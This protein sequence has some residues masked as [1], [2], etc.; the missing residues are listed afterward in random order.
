MASGKRKHAEDDHLSL[1]KNAKK[2]KL[3]KAS[4]GKQKLENTTSD[5]SKTKS[6]NGRITNKQKK[7]KKQKDAKPKDSHPKEEDIANENGNIETESKQNGKKTSK[8]LNKWQRYKKKKKPQPGTPKPASTGGTGKKDAAST[9]STS[10]KSG[11]AIV[12][13]KPHLYNPTKIPSSN[14]K[15][16]QADIQKTA[17][18]RKHPRKHLK[19]QTSDD[20]TPQKDSDKPDIWFDDVDEELIYPTK[21]KPKTN[22]KTNSNLSPIISIRSWSCEGTLSLKA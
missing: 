6:V 5:P 14:W 11:V 3:G 4:P 17:P 2:I 19:K 10:R 9:D 7:V 8:H 22:I 15:Q 13:G 12:T 18:K 1:H 21:E 20:P 16:L